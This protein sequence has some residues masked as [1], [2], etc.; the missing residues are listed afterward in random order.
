MKDIPLLILHGWNLSKEKFSPLIREL[1]KR[2]YQV[3]CPDLPGF[4]KANKPHRSFYLSDYADF[5]EYFIKKKNFNQ[6]ILIGHSFGGRIGIKLAVKNPNILRAL[7]LTGTPGISPVSWYKKSFFW[8]LA[9]MGKT[10]L[11]LPFFSSI[12]EKLKKLLYKFAGATDY[13]Q[14]TKD[15]KQTFRNITKENLIPYLSQVVTPVLL[16]WGEEDRIV[17]KDIADKMA[18]LMKKTRVITIPDAR[19]GVP[20]THAKVFAE[21]VDKF[22]KYEI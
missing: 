1:M 2:D 20:W 13:Y 14:T 7:I 10:F 18:R 22:L 6:V 21:I 4:G 16:I 11:L 5:I 9:K 17:P 15:M 8:M 19:H 12:S 3:Y